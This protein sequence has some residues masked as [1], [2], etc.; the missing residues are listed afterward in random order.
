MD[1]SE[2]QNSPSPL[3][4][5][6][7]AARKPHRDGMTRRHG[8]L[9]M[10]CIGKDTPIFYDMQRIIECKPCNYCFFYNFLHTSILLC[11]FAASKDMP[12]VA[13]GLWSGL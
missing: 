2:I 13:V 1:L 10:I 11:I 4:T 8:K 3:P 7:K 5:N 9:L 12:R 6:S